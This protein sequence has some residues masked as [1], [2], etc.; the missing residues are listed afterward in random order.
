MRKTN[1]HIGADGA[2]VV[3]PRLLHSTQFGLLCPI[4]SPDGGNV[5]LHKHLSTSTHITSGCSGK[6]LI[7]YLRNIKSGIKILEECSY[8]YLSNSTKIFINGNWIGCTM[9]H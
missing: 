7:K 1:L 5:G 9:T 8:E 3:K 4:H 6:P 2:K